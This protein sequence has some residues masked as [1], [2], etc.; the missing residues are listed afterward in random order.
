MS[1]AQAADNVL[2]QLEHALGNGRVPDD[3]KRRG[4][5]LL[6][7]LK[8]PVQVTLIGKPGS[9]KSR[10]VNM[11]TG[12]SVIPDTA[13]L[14]PLE[15]SYGTHPRTVYLMADG[16]E[17]ASDGLHLDQPIPPDTAIVRAELPLTVLTGMS[18][19]ELTL[20]GSPAE[21]K[22]IVEWALARANIVLW[23]SQG[24]DATE[25]ALWSPAKDALKDHSFL[26]LTKADQLQ[27]KGVL[28]ER[29][30]QLEDVV[31]EE[32][33]RMYP[34]ATIQAISA[35]GSNG[36]RDEGIWT[37]SGGRALEDAVQ[38]LVET[39]RNADADNALVFLNR[40]KSVLPRS[41]TVA[42]EQPAANRQ[43][44]E[45]TT[46][47]EPGNQPDAQ[48]PQV[49]RQALE[50][51]QSRADLMLN[52]ID[53]DTPDKQ[54]LVLDH[55]LETANKLSEIMM[56]ADQADGSFSE[57]QEDVME[58][59]DMMILFHLER[60]EDAADEAVTMLLQLKKEMTVAATT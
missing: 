4:A 43:T 26:V 39:G 53:A 51:L 48:T 47:P 44:H 24:F 22:A 18:L 45:S 41:E 54:E 1:M 57:I 19:T 37:S 58:C 42:P 21:Q 14:P 59:S 7:R 15:V 46:Q 10:L 52:A 34:V 29:I 33:Y 3:E 56:Q 50:F 28:S 25:Q 36:A 31:A 6:T 40:H 20:S 11:L 23:C 5:Q 12:E 8:R 9:G 27:M 55:C 35:S 60:T 32:F 30:G 16:S 13:N 38:R 2:E 17:Q 49:F